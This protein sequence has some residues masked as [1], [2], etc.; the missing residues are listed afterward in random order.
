MV[1]EVL[2]ACVGKPSAGKS[3]FLNA[4]S[5]AAAKVGNY[6]FTT[7]K[8]NHGVSYVPIDCVCKK[9]DKK[10]DCR[11][12]YGRCVDGVR[13]VPIQIMD[14]AGLVPGASEGQ[15]LGNQ[16]LDDLRHAQALI[17][18][19]DVSGTT[20]QNGK[21]T[22]GYDPINDI[23]WLRTEI[24]SWISNNLLK[25]WGS[26]IRRHVALK[27][28][29]V[30]TLQTQFSGYGSTTLVVAKAL[31]KSG[32]KTPLE[33]WDEDTVK[34]LVEF[35]M[36]E[37]FPTIVAMNKIDHP[38]ADKNITRIMRRYDQ[39][40]LVLTSALAEN[41]LRKIQKQ[42]YINYVEGTDMVDTK[43][44]L[45]DSDLKEM[46]EKLKNRVEKV[47]DLVLYRYGS[48]GVQDVLVKAIE[49]LGV[50]PV[51]PVKNVTSFGASSGS[52]KGGA[53]RDCVLLWPGTTVREFAKILHPEI[54]KYYLYAET[55]G[56][57]R[58]AEDAIITQDNNIISFKTSQSVS[59][60]ATSSH[61]AAP[62]D[63][64]ST[65]KK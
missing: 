18:V 5:D 13:Y 43:E 4:V 26:I 51:Y 12:R 33:S 49:T 46:D 31:D 42:G 39:N 34:K 14:V 23:N 41:F 55:A 6:P 19:V 30:D 37:R 59:K 61:D 48:T 44:D 38:D 35:F 8:P 40:K 24:H 47:Q 53:F 56:N 52:S 16:F 2:I 60:N 45:P 3:S 62:T 28:N 36:D 65:T 63:K 11:P 57:I 54:D 10:D 32:I 20:D 27:A 64:K 21:E 22:Q 25:R 17:H 29:P 58:L 7:I 50:V 9:H 15:G 1:K